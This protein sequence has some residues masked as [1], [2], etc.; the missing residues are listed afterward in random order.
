MHTLVRRYIKTAI[1][2]LIAGLLLGTWMIIQRELGGG[3]LAPSLVSAHTHLLLVGFVMFMILGVGQWI[4]PR[5]ASGDT[6]Y[7]PRAAE[8]VYWLL[9]VSTA[10]RAVAEVGRAWSAGIWLRWIVVVAATMQVAGL[11]LYFWVMRSRIRPG[12]SEL[13]ERRGERF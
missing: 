4:F 10:V 1:G 7:Q 8:A 2:F 9:L 6:R 13:R 11:A 5:P 3:A 12:G